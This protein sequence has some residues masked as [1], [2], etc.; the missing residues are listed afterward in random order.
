MAEWAGIILMAS[1]IALGFYG[2]IASTVQLSASTQNFSAFLERS[3]DL[4][5]IKNA[6]KN[7][8]SGLSRGQAT[9]GLSKIGFWIFLSGTAVFM[10]SRRQRWNTL[11]AERQDSS[12]NET[13]QSGPGYPPQSVGSPDP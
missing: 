12:E 6:T 5:E 3:G 13:E 9:A 10:I 7:V 11:I 1:G 2:S 8:S 4:S